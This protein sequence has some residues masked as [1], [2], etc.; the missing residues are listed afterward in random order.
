MVNFTEGVGFIIISLVNSIIK[1]D[2]KCVFFLKKYCLKKTHKDEKSCTAGTHRSHLVNI[3]AHSHPRILG[4]KQSLFLLFEYM[5]HFFA[6]E[7]TQRQKFSRVQADTLFFDQLHRL[8]KETASRVQLLGEKKT[9]CVPGN[10]TPEFALAL[11]PSLS[12][13]DYRNAILVAAHTSCLEKAL[14]ECLPN[15]VAIGHFFLFVPLFFLL[16]LC[17]PLPLKAQGQPSCDQSCGYKCELM[18]EDPEAS[19]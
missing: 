10:I 18:P 7:R 5:L 1:Q 19:Q 12:G 6:P 8:R 15:Q 17:A 14:H 9:F 13:Q 11:G 2:V 4:L 16:L 3:S